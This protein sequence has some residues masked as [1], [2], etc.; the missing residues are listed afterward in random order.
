MGG[1]GLMTLMRRR[2]RT[3]GLRFLIWRVHTATMV[4]EPGSLMLKHYMVGANYRLLCEEN[5]KGTPF[6]PTPQTPNGE[7]GSFI[8]P[9][10]PSPDID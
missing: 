1:P 4:A 2:Q 9:H 7:R 6:D 8:R 3:P 10:C 5:L